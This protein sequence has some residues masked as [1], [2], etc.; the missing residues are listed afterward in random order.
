MQYIVSLYNKICINKGHFAIYILGTW[1]WDLGGV[2]CFLYSSCS[3]PRSSKSWSGLFVVGW[4]GQNL[5]LVVCV[6]VNLAALFL[7]SCYIHIHYSYLYSIQQQPAFVHPQ[8]V[9]VASREQASRKCA[10]SI[11][12]SIR[13]HL[14]TKETDWPHPSVQTLAHAHAQG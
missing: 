4:L 12:I 9:A 10:N 5:S 7:S 6:C 3:C 13:M 1:D 14:Q 2:S 11:S 8:T